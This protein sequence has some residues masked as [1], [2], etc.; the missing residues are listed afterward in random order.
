MLSEATSGRHRSAGLTR[1]S[2]VMPGAP[3]VVRLTTTLEDC[4]ITRRNGSKASGLWS[5]RPSAGLRAWRCTIAA[6]ASA[7]PSA[8]SAISS[9]VTGRCGDIEGVWIEP[10]TAQLMMTFR[11]AMTVSSDS[12]FSRERGPAFFERIAVIRRRNGDQRLRA[13]MVA[14]APEISGAELRDDD[15]GV[16]PAERDRSDP[17]AGSDDAADR[18]PGGRCR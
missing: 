6:P 4:L 10:V 15:V 8:D 5:G 14:E 16:H 17:C 11:L 7:A 3:P 13:V 9:A 18:A 2:M 12:E 1:S